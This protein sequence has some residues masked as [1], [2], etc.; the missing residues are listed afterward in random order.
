MGFTLSDG[1]YDAYIPCQIHDSHLHMLPFYLNNNELLDYYADA[2]EDGMEKKWIGAAEANKGRTSTNS[3]L[4]D[5][6]FL[7]W[8][9]KKMFFLQGYTIQ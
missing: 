5:K 2:M 9:T 6:I 7:K 8:S 4:G 3:T 1:K